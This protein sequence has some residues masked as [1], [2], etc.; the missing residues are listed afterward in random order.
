MN[1][2]Y[3]V[4]IFKNSHNNNLIVLISSNLIIEFKNFKKFFCY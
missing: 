3:N 2:K 1:Y 4:L